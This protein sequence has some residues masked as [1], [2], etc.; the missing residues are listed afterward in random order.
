MPDLGTVISNIISSGKG[1]E[2]DLYLTFT[3][4]WSFSEIKEG[5]DEA[6]K[7]AKVLDG[8]AW[9]GVEHTIAQI[10]ELVKNGEI[11]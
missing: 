4:S 11:A 1:G 7:K 10:R 6:A 8:M 2:Q 3:F 9:D 5:T